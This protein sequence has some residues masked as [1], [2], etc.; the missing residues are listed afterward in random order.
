MVFSYP[1]QFSKTDD[2][3]YEGDIRQDLKEALTEKLKDFR[4]TPGIN[5]HLFYIHLSYDVASGS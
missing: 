1:L 2:S 5:T 4:T 3:R